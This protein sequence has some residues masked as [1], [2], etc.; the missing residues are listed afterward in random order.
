[1]QL[2]AVRPLSRISVEI[3]RHMAS[4]RSSTRHSVSPRTNAVPPIGIEM[5][6]VSADFKQTQEHLSKVEN[7]I[8][9]LKTRKQLLDQAIESTVRSTRDAFRSK[10]FKTETEQMRSSVKEIEQEQL[11]SFRFQRLQHKDDRRKRW[12]MYKEALL[13]QRRSEAKRCKFE[14]EQFDAL[15][16]EQAQ[17]DYEKKAARRISI[18]AE[19]KVSKMHRDLTRARQTEFLRQDYLNRMEKKR[20]KK[21]DCVD[22]LKA[23]ELEETQLIESLRAS[24]QQ[25]NSVQERLKHISGSNRPQTQMDQSQ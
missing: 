24:W 13:L 6:N 5:L 9:L 19:R 11:K 16:R 23:L 8:Q 2:V 18:Q 20:A 1:M 14:S 25:H 12:T 22:R 10:S 17:K 3:P 7:R 15:A 4:S 21:Q